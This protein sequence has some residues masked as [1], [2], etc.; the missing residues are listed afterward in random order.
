MTV[1]CA[2]PSVP[3][4]TPSLP[5]ARG[6]LT[7]ALFASLRGRAGTLSGAVTGHA[8]TDDPLYGEDTPLAL[9]TLY[10]LHYRGFAGVD[11]GWEWDSDLL[12]LRSRLEHA[13]LARLQ[14]EV[15]ERFG[16]EPLR[17]H[18]VADELRALA[19][20]DG[21]SLSTFMVNEGTIDQMREFAVHRSPYQLKEA[22]PHTW[23]IPRLQ[24]S[25]KAALVTIQTDEYGGGQRCAMHSELFAD[26]MRT[27]GLDA[28]YGAL[29]E[30]V[31]GATLSTVNLVSLFGLHRRWRGALIGH[32]ALF[33]MCSIAPMGRYAEAL[34]RMGVPE[35]GP[36][37]TAHVI[38]DQWHEK[39]ALDDMVGGLVREQPALSDDIVFGARAL[40]HL[41]RGLTRR[42]LSAWSGGDTS[43][44]RGMALTPPW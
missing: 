33:E 21:P 16:S 6:P 17:P 40:D 38:A 31:P 2:L 28:E 34:Q 25:T 27:L 41:E 36:F 10:E 4:I 14:D 44:R 3:M 18:D 12:R 23:A 37:Y 30:L 42:L 15:A 13:F 8:I 26:A 11:D 32:L 29:L 1:S 43:L 7:E 22:D 39:I 19:A 35:A 24:G 9:Y 20:A 5:E